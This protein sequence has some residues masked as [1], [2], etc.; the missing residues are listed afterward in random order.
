MVRLVG[1]EAEYWIG[2]L[3]ADGCVSCRNG[4]WDTAVM[5]MKKDKEHLQKLKKFLGVHRKITETKRGE[6]K[7]SVR[8]AELAEQLVKHGVVPKKTYTAEVIGLEHSRD[9]WR[10]VVDGDGCVGVYAARPV[11]SLCGSHQLMAQYL[12]FVKSKIK[13]RTVVRR[14]NTGNYSTVD[15]TSRKAIQIIEILYL[16][17]GI[18]LDRKKQKADII[19]RDEKVL[20]PGQFGEKN[21]NSVLTDE[22]VRFLRAAGKEKTHQ[23]L[24][25]RFHVSRYTVRSIRQGR[26]RR[27]VCA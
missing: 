23:E 10:G 25:D 12:S 13:T 3:M 2:F 16:N 8:S 24:A 26:S 6:V 5:L 17:S 9:F 27:G 20:C 7:L 14:S 21:P 15:F 4:H 19:L 22:Q 1:Q 11:L 18:S